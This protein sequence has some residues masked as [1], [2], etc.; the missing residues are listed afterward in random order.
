MDAREPS[1]LGAGRLLLRFG[2]GLVR[3]TREGAGSLLTAA[4]EAAAREAATPPREH[5]AT[6]LAARHAALG[7]LLELLDL[8]ARAPALVGAR[9]SR[10]VRPARRLAGPLARVG[11]LAGRAPGA[12]RAAA[13]LRGWRARGAAKLAGWAVV[14]RR[15][16]AESRALARAAVATVYQTALGRVAESP[17]LKQVIREQSQGIAVTAVT[18]LRHRSASADNLAEGA[19]RRLLGRGQRGGS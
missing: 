2:V 10:A 12:A 18:E 11:R 4:S 5:E 15:E 3:L 16:E 9:L 8:G 13:R 6:P 14:G 19:V 7:L 1:R 17:S